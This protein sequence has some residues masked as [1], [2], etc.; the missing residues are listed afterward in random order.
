MKSCQLTARKVSAVKNPGYYGDGGGL[1]LQVSK[2]GTKTWVFRFM[3]AGRARE[4]GLGTLD[5][6]SLR[7]ARERARECRQILNRGEDPIEERK[8]RRDAAR[9]A[10]A[11]R[12]TFKEA[13]EKYID[14]H[15]A[16]WRSGKHRDQWANTLKAYAYPIMGKLPID[17]IDLP[18]VLNVLEPIWTTKTETA[19]RLRGRI[20]RILAWATVRKYRKGENPA[21][22]AGHLAEMLP[23]KTKVWTPRHHAA[24]PFVEVP[25]LVAGLRQ[26]DGL[27]ARALELAVLTALRANE[28]LG[29][30]WDEVEGATWTVPASRMKSGKAHRVPLSS[31][32]VDILDTLPRDV[33]S[34]LIFPGRIRGRPIS[35]D[36]MLDL[37]KDMRPGVVVHGLRSSFSD[38]ARERTSYPRD[39]VEM[40]LAHTVRDKTEAAY[41]RGDALEKRRRLMEEWARYCNSPAVNAVG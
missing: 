31:R 28:V 23:A 29:A 41:R 33:A 10:A 39:V 27:A 34:D 22:W 8:K 16:G 11:G 24:L 6:F 3:V 25:A 30:R 14:A 15:A 20:E 35:N 5:T 37:L 9:A 36:T 32:A 26:L 38:W 7:G 12:I 2:Y 19:S 13:A 4:M 21:R 17:A 1:Y 18:H 40:A